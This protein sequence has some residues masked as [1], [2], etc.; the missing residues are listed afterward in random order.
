M[1]FTKEKAVKILFEAAQEYKKNLLGKNILL[2]GQNKHKEITTLEVAFQASNFMHLTGC[3]VDKKKISARDF[4]K[5]CVDK[6]LGMADFEIKKDGTTELK[7]KILISLVQKDLSAN[8]MGIYNNRGPML[9]TDRLAGSVKGGLGFTFDRKR[10]KYVPNTVIN[11]D[12]RTYISNPSRIFAIYIK[13]QKDEKYNELVYIAKQIN[14]EE[15]IYP[16]EISYLTK[17]Q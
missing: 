16:Q 5:R 14:W 2:L 7:L 9:L 10:G 11:A 6:R 3:I 13:M 1:S 8:M 12:I 4:F 15:V 17:P